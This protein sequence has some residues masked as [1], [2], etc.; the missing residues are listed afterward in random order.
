MNGCFIKTSFKRRNLSIIV[1]GNIS[2]CSLQ[3]RRTITLTRSFIC[4]ICAF[5]VHFM[6]NGSE[7]YGPQGSH[8]VRKFAR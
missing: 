2:L 6:A 4:A 5:L 8:K 7:T 3:H 1:V